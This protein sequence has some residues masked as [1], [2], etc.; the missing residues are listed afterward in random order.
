MNLD[1]RIFSIGEVVGL[2]LVVASFVAYVIE[3]STAYSLLFVVGFLLIV[4]GYVLT[5]LDNRDRR[6]AYFEAIEDQEENGVFLALDEDYVPCE[7]EAEIEDLRE[8]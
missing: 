4:V 1:S 5:Y 8:R 6:T 7:D 2:V 3:P